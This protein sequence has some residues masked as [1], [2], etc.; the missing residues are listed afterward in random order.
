MS[1]LVDCSLYS[2]KVNTEQ[3]KNSN[4]LVVFRKYTTNTNTTKIIKLQA[5]RKESKKCRSYGQE[6]SVG[7]QCC[8]ISH[9]I[10]QFQVQTKRFFTLAQP[11]SQRIWTPQQI[12]TP[13]SKSPSR[14]GPPLADMDPLFKTLLYMGLRWPSSQRTCLS[15]L[16][17]QVQVSVTRGSKSTSGYGP[18][19]QIY[20]GPNQLGHRFKRRVC[21]VRLCQTYSTAKVIRQSSALFEG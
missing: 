15:P 20:G 17:P 7:C 8:G 16:R 18:G 9:F 4:K 6:M 2:M 14:Y 12:W 21:P 5:Q 13:R 10:C 19:V 1:V 11:V 3:H